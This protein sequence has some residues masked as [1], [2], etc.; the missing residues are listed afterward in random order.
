MFTCLVMVFGE[1][2]CDFF[3]S[4]RLR[5]LISLFSSNGNASQIVGVTARFFMSIRY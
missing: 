4:V 3:V 2:N 5:I 1:I